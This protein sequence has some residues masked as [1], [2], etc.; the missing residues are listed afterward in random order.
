VG[1]GC[2]IQ[3][4]V[5]VYNGVVLEEGVFCGPS[6]VFTNVINPRAFI[7][8]KSEFKRTLVRQGATVGANA[9][10]VCGVTIGTYALVGAG[11]VV[12]KDVPAYALIYGVPARRGGWVCRCGVA[13]PADLV[14]PECADRYEL[15]DDQLRPAP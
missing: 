13:L 9:T 8:R 7:E 15:T 12:T 2:K 11:A 1:N 4:N 3:N 14:C 6:M 10:V 5:S